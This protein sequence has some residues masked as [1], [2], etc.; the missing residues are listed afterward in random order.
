M[1]IDPVGVDENNVHSHN[2]YAYANNN[3]YKFVNPDGRDAVLVGNQVHINPVLASIPSVVIPNTAGALGFNGSD[4][5]F[6]KY[7]FD[8][9]SNLKLNQASS[10]ISNNPTPGA[11]RPASTSGTTNDVGNL[12]IFPGPN[13]VKSY[14]VP[15]PDKS[16]YTDIT[17]NYTIKGEHT[18]DE[19]FVMRYGEINSRGGTTIRTYGEGNAIKQ[20][21]PF[22]DS[23]AR[24]AWKGVNK[25]INN[26]AR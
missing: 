19:G 11:D 9:S 3:P 8:D 25:E 5:G 7:S 1:G 13:L 12:S 26:S 21:L 20:K 14:I 10:G 6:H 15:S 22:A 4:T 18:L 16:K 23:F 17:V 2:R 24:K